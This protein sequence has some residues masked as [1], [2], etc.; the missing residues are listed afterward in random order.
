MLLIMMHCAM[1]GTTLD[2]RFP[3][4]PEPGKKVL[5]SRGTYITCS[6]SDKNCEISILIFDSKQITSRP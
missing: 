5:P 1:V 2:D 4:L 3:W 6:Y